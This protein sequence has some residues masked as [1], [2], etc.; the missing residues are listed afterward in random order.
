[1][2]T[3]PDY[4]DH[5]LDILSIGLNPSTTSVEKG[6]YFANPRNRFWNAFNASGLI[7]EDVIPSKDAQVKIFKQYKIGFTDVVK[8]H[9]SMSKYLRATDYKE[10]APKL[11]IKI[12]RYQPK[13]CWFHGKVAAKNYLKFTEQMGTKIDWGKQEIKIKNSILF[14][15]PNPSPANAAYSLEVIIKWYKKLNDLKYRIK[16]YQK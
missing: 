9:S 15:T 13:I 10:Y 1:M 6:F 2:K 5:G 14:I 16:N 4:I 7:P 12:E 3:L 11:K 8:R